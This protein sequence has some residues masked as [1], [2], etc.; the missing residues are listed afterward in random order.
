[1]KLRQQGCLA[2]TSASLFVD[3]EGKFSHIHVVQI[4]AV[5]QFVCIRIW[6]SIPRWGLL[7]QGRKKHARVCLLRNILLYTHATSLD[8]PALSRLHVVQPK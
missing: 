7:R 8:S 4:T 6:L 5:Q 3:V 1:M 2:V